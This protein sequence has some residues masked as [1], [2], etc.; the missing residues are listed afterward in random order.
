MKA[1]TKIGRLITS[2]TVISRLGSAGLRDATRGIVLAKTWKKSSAE[3]RAAN[4]YLLVTSAEL[5]NTFAETFHKNATSDTRL[6]ILREAGNSTDQ[7][8]S[9]ILDLRIQT[10]HRFYVIDIFPELDHANWQTRV[11]CLLKR[12]SSTIAAE[13]K[14]DRIL[15]AA[16]QGDVLHVVSPEFT[17]LDVPLAY[18]P[19][20]GTG[21]SSQVADF[22]LD[23][24]GAFIYWPNLDLHLGWSQL[25]QLVDSKA[26]QHASQKR[27][28]FNARYGKAVYA[29][30]QAAGIRSS[31]L[32]GL[33]EK[34]LGQIEKGECLLTSDAIKALSR[35]HGLKPNE[36]LQSL[37]GSQCTN[38][39][40]PG[41]LVN[42]A[43]IL[44]KSQP[45]NGKGHSNR[46]INSTGTPPKKKKSKSAKPKV[47]TPARIIPSPVV[48][49]A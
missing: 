12:L 20:L 45:V 4:E 21:K 39:E 27:D 15:D 44:S 42:I 38:F 24:D 3:S 32:S 40:G 26:V 11:L 23:D 46:N 47:K 41:S 16:I 17:R 48:A 14:K 37:A 29:V 9:R 35:A 5:D 19:A 10:P 7:L 25:L 30:R 28:Q 1:S 31:D 34:E 49:S 6:L 2:G 8:I 13:N 18:I 43:D 33:S 36:Y 22:E